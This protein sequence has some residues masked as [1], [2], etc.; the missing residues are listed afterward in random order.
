MQSQSDIRDNL[1]CICD[2][3]RYILH[4]N[5]LDSAILIVVL[6]VLQLQF[7]EPKSVQL[8]LHFLDQGVLTSQ[9]ILEGTMKPQAR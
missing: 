5:P 6:T 1:I 3:I 9:R 8:C 7:F 2:Y 4:S